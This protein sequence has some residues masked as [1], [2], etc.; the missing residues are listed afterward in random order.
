MENMKN[1]VEVA[2][3]PKK[4]VRIAPV[5]SNQPPAVAPGFEL[6]PKDATS[7]SFAAPSSQPTKNSTTAMHFPPPAPTS[8]SAPATSVASAVLGT[9]NVIAPQQA[10]KQLHEEGQEFMCH[11]N[12]AIRFWFPSSPN[13]L[14]EI[15]S[16]NAA[17]STI[18]PAYT[19]QLFGD[20]ETIIGF[21]ELTIDMIYSAST[22]RLLYQETFS[23]RLVTIGQI[24]SENDIVDKLREALPGGWTRDVDAFRSELATESTSFIP[25]GEVVHQYDGYEVRRSVPSEDSRAKEIHERVETMA[26]YTIDGATYADLDDHRWSVYTVYRLTDRAL[27]GYMTVF[28]FDNPFRTNISLPRKAMRVCQL[29]IMPQHQRQ[30]HGRRLLEVAHAEVRRLDMY[31]LTVED[32][33]NAF[34]RMRDSMDMRCCLEKNYFHLNDASWSLSLDNNMDTIR[35]DMRV[36]TGQINKCYEVLKLHALDQSIS[37]VAATTTTTTTTTTSSSMSNFRLNVKR[38]LWNA[39]KAELK[40]IEDKAVRMQ[41]IELLW[42]EVASNYRVSYANAF[43]AK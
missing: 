26:M 5:A 30:G 21:K 43:G 28:T 20:D 32:P 29:L 42:R 13:E 33:N 15:L 40:K 35:T 11:A 18:H 22:F 38:R 24:P 1:N 19:H 23:D 3:R 17:A 31:E 37:S 39:H 10:I 36:T 7:V 34:T 25:P 4:R 27:V 2:P 12:K 16:N 41:A 9:T 8:T 6:K 14:N